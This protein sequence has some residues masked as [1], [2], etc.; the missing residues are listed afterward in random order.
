MA[1]TAGPKKGPAAWAT[2][3]LVGAIVL[4]GCGGGGDGDTRQGDEAD[5][6]GSGV[7]IAKITKK[8]WLAVPLGVTEDEVVAKFGEPG[9][10]GQEGEIN[11]FSYWLDPDLESYVGFTF[12]TETHRLEDKSWTVETSDSRPIRKAQ[13]R[14]VTNGMT[15]AQVTKVLGVPWERIDDVSS[16]T[17]AERSV[18]APGTLQRCFIYTGITAT[19]CF[20]QAGKVN[21]TYPP[22]G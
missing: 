17:V 10:R 12:D 18:A 16:Y 6:G 21:Y 4:A 19:I 5:G 9:K 8:Q 3:A 7:K 15:E 13:Y 1:I 14:Q 2:G 20:D 22:N 11:R